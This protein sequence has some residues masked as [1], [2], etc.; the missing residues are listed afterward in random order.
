MTEEKGRH[1]T[2]RKRESGNGIVNTIEANNGYVARRL[3]LRG[4][5]VG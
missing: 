5:V 2:A 1:F 4:S 3:Q